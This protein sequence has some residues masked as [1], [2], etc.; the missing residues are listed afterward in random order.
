M[1]SNSRSVMRVSGRGRLRQTTEIEHD[2]MSVGVYGNGRN[3][4]ALGGN[5][6][7]IVRIR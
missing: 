2:I 7:D 6:A 5:C 3:A 4:L 1:V